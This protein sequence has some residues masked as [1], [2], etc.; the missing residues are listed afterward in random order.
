MQFR[1]KRE[2][3]RNPLVVD[4]ADHI[5]EEDHEWIAHQEVF[6]YF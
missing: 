6:S 3:K 2:L 1:S 5:R 4:N